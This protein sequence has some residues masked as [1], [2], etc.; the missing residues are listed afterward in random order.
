MLHIPAQNNE[1]AKDIL[2]CRAK[3]VVSG[4]NV[5]RSPREPDSSAVVNVERRSDKRDLIRAIR[6]GFDMLLLQLLS[7]DLIPFV[8][9]IVMEFC[10]CSCRRGVVID[11]LYCGSCR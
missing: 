7:S 9:L 8:S 11:V 2:R 6:D 10:I 4:M 3:A 5:P 1:G